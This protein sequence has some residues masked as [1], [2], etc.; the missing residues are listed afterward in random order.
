M[1]VGALGLWAAL[2]GGAVVPPASLGHQTCGLRHPLWPWMCV[3][4]ACAC[5]GCS[6]WGPPAAD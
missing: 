5:P 6:L 4:A 1:R 3:R 2:G